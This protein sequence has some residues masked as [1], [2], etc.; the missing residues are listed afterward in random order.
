MQIRFSSL[1]GDRP[2]CPV[3]PNHPVDHHG[4]YERCANC[5]DNQKEAIDR[6]LCRPCGHT[7]SVLPDQFLPYSAASVSLTQ[8]YF[9]AQAHP[10]LTK[11]PAITEKEKGCLKRAW[12]RFGQR[13]T[14]LAATLGQI[15]QMRVS[16][17]S[18]LLWSGLR[19]LGNLGDILLQLAHPFNTSLLHDY[20]CL[21]PWS[22]TPT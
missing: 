2:L 3:D 4:I 1:R 22:P 7:I 16:N 12:K 19:R 5:N 10:S 8:K 14:A 20:L 21:W 17:S 18:K 15:M 11:V 9:D 6:Y 13:T